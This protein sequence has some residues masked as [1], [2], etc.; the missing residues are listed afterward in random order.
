MPSADSVSAHL[1]SYGKR[2]TLCEAGRSGTRCA[3]GPTRRSTRRGQQDL[4]L[5]KETRLDQHAQLSQKLIKRIARQEP[6][7]SA[8]E[9][10]NYI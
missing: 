1:Y 5:Q 9:L 8:A 2:E 10:L 3:G 4:S 6:N 7:L